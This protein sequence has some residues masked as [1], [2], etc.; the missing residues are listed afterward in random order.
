M[1]DSGVAT[2]MGGLGVA[3]LI[4]GGGMLFWGGLMTGR[5]RMLEK[6]VEPIA[7]LRTDMATLTERMDHLIRLLEHGEG[8]APRPRGRGRAEHA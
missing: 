3:V 6:A 7:T 4:E 2:I 5:V 8:A 1:I